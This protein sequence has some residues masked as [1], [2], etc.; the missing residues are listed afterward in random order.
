MKK[1]LLSVMFLLL[2]ISTIS[3]AQIKSSGAKGLWGDAATWE[4][5]NVPTASDDVII[6]TGDSVK[7][8][9]ATA[10]CKN[11]TIQGTL[12]F[13]KTVIVAFTV[14]GN[15]SIETGAIFKTQT[16]GI[17][18]P[19]G[20]LAH[21]LE[22]K[23]NLTHNG[24]S[25]D[26]RN[27]TSGST[28][29]V[30]NLILSGTGNS[31]ITINGTYS[32]TN[33]DF[34]A[35]K[36]NKT[37]T[38]KVI[39]GSNMYISGGSTTG[40]DIAQSN[41]VFV[42]G[43]IETGNFVLVH[44]STT[45][46]T[47]SGY[48]QASYVVGAMGRGISSSAAGNKVFP[49]G[50]ARSFRPFTLYSSTSGSATGHHAIVRC[51]S[52]NANTGTSTFAGGI[53]KVSAV[54]YYQIGYN[55]APGTSGAA[56]MGFNNFKPSYGTDDGVTAN[57]NNVRVAYSVDRAVW[58]G[59]T[60]TTPDTVRFVTPPKQISPDALA[61]AITLNQGSS[62]YVSLA[63]ASGSIDNPLTEVRKEE[64]LPTSFEL[65]QNYPNPFNPATSI[66][67]SI[68]KSAF[69]TL[70]IYNAI[71]QEVANLINEIKDPGNYKLN[72]DAAKLSSGIYF[73]RLEAGNFVST[74]K[75]V[76]MK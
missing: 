38:G 65:S 11:L 40:P 74:K 43:I 24:T 73:Y 75:M 57:S 67:F 9:T 8:N 4:G 66:S 5:G 15:I 31:T 14:N 47:V 52:G 48:S 16:S 69:V 3:F 60:Q 53:D 25:L 55:T 13:S 12:L 30:C 36:I 10:V 20:D 34:N 50:D 7:F 58:T 37:G 1:T 19:V 71:G 29:G 21:T 49:I 68:P 35:V 6:V 41:L 72:F 63:R 32:S 54:R 44:Q 42:N 26:F 23:G 17:T 2:A 46:A 22:L 28:I 39:L 27:G 59:M 61:T 70:K 56:S 51:I 33:G 76:L 64:G 45:S 62:M 18:N